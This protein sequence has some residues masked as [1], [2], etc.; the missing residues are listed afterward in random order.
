MILD[1]SAANATERKIQAGTKPFLIAEFGLNHNR[2][3]DLARRMA[4]A[5]KASGV[6]AVKLQSYTTRFFINRQF[7]NVHGLYDIFAGLELETGRQH[8]V[9]RLGDF[10]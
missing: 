5:A 8:P 2:D 3:I 7:E 10:G 6:D 9:Q 4:D 1:R